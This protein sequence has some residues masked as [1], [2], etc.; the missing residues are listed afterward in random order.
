MIENVIFSNS[1]F[2]IFDIKYPDM[3]RNIN[4]NKTQLA[5][6]VHLD[7]TQ[8]LII[9]LLLLARLTVGGISNKSG[10]TVAVL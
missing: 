5:V 3:T 7:E 10:N 8:L 4:A 2:R 9:R 6:N 1:F